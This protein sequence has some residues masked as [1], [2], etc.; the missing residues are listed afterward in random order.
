V[1]LRAMCVL[2]FVA[3]ATVRVV[4][5]SRRMLPANNSTSGMTG[6]RN[7]VT[8]NLGV[9]LPFSGNYSWSLPRI[10]PAITLAVDDVISTSNTAFRSLLGFRIN[11]GNSECSETMGP[12]AAIDMY[13]E[14]RA[15]VFIGPVCDYAVSPVA[16][17]SAHWNIPV[18]TAGALVGA[19]HLK[20]SYRLLT[21]LTSPYSQLGSFV[22]D[23]L[24]AKF[25][26][27]SA[28]IVYENYLGVR[29]TKLGRSTC[30]F[31]VE[32]V[33]MAMQR[34]RAANNASGTVIWLKAFDPGGRGR[35]NSTTILRELQLNAR[36]R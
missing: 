16:R 27:T 4:S 3:M 17:F 35:F 20:S 13:L 6:S 7:V 29:A 25:N 28:G 34:R 15:D 23:Q 36:S 2:I 10:K 14:R 32:G 1:P 12:L 30:Y 19:F 5:S 24:I 33:Y 26:W 31:T 11:Y 21:R 18:V 8:M 9:I 22:V